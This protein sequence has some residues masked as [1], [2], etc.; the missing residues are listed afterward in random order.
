MGPVVTVLTTTLRAAEKAQE[1]ISFRGEESQE[2]D[3]LVEEPLTY[4]TRQIHGGSCQY[5]ED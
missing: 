1:A 3:R 4:Q 5:W 2:S